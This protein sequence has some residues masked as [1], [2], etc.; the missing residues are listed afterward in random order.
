MHTYGNGA[1]ETRVHPFALKGIMVYDLKDQEND[2]SLKNVHILKPTQAKAI[3]K[4]GYYVSVILFLETQQTL[5]AF[6]IL[7]MGFPCFSYSFS[8]TQLTSLSHQAFPQGCSSLTRHPTLGS[9]ICTNQL[10]N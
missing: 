10:Y 2:S 1:S 7:N 6:L 5:P 4:S 8:L 3:V 9:C